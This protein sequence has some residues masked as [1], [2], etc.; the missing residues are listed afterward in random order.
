MY[1]KFMLH[2]PTD[3]QRKNPVIVSSDLQ[4]TLC[5]PCCSRWSD[6]TWVYVCD[7]ETEELIISVPEKHQANLF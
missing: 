4:E 3:K 1:A 2:L 7:P 6:E 5:K